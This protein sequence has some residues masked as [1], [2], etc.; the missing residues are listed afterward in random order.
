M[1]G[2]NCTA[3]ATPK[4]ALRTFILLVKMIRYITSFWSLLYILNWLSKAGPNHAGCLRGRDPA[5]RPAQFGACTDK[6]TI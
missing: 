5:S 4:S 1:H 2:G 6:I 3:G